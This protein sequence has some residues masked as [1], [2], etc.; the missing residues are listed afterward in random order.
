MLKD[1]F[2]FF[3]ENKTKKLKLAGSNKESDILI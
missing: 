2:I 1:I 3:Y